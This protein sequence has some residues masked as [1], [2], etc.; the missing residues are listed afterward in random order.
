M[1]EKKGKLTRLE[2]IEEFSRVVR[3]EPVEAD[4]AKISA[5]DE[6]YKKE[7]DKEFNAFSEEKQTK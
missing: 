4:Q 6:Q 7:I 5:F 2:M 3:L 1:I